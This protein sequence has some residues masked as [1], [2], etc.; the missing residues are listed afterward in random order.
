MHTPERMKPRTVL[1]KIVWQ[2]REGQPVCAW[3]DNSQAKPLT[4]HLAQLGHLS[5]A[6]TRETNTS[7]E[8]S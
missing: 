3:L 8:R 2:R 7:N 6:A 1:E 5:G 4:R